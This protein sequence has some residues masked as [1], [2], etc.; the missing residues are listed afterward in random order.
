M[1]MQ[2]RW[3]IALLAAGAGLTLA[4][5]GS[6]GLAAAAS[7]AGAAGSAAGGATGVSTERVVH[8]ARVAGP[9]RL[10]PALGPSVPGVL[11]SVAA[12]SPDNVWAAGLTSGPALL[13]HWDGS[14]W[15][16]YAF[17]P[18]IYFTSVAVISPTDAWAVGGTYWFSPTLTVAYHWN[19]KTWSQVPTPTPDGSAFFNGVAATSADNAWAVGSISGGPGDQ[20]YSVPLIEHWN[21]KK[22][23]RQY[24]RLPIHSGYFISVAAT[25]PDNAWA[26]G[27]TGSQAPNGALIEHWNGKQWKRL[28]ANTPDGFG[29]VQGVTATS[30]D[31]AWAVGFTDASS[32][33]Q[34]LTLHWNGKTWSVVASPNP[35][36]DTNL[37]KVSATSPD[38]AWAVGY[39]SPTT[40]SPMCG[41]IAIHWNGKRWSV[42]PTP[43]PP[44]ESLDALL[45]IDAISADDA[46]A[47]GTTDWGSTIIAHWNGHTWS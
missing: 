3:A 10:T 31:N 20:G 4:A 14:A 45:G 6:A 22:W 26:V 44:A 13:L 38:N 46:W 40:C 7:G 33:D 23:T 42:V 35:T 9:G 12:S 34:S 25:S 32:V 39:T 37:A 2:L 19:G 15:W 28:P 41:T 30:A 47:V 36:G 18:D 17:S 24:F 1:R 5:P 29:V 27:M 11:Y 43:D 8:A 16:Q 21:G